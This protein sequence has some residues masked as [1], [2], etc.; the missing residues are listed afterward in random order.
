MLKTVPELIAEASA[1]LKRLDAKSAMSEA[2]QHDGLIIDVR[3]PSE[4][5]AKP[6]SRSINIPR[7][8]VEMMMREK[9][10]SADQ[11]IYVHCAT[12]GRAVLATEQ[13]ERMGYTNVT[14]IT[15]PIDTVCEAMEA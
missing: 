3:E 11:P 12:G 7:G 1:T 14:A 5:A 15:C 13:L 10:P 2:M 6:A 9:F 8:V 4:V